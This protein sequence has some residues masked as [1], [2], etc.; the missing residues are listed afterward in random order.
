MSGALARIG[1]SDAQANADALRRPGP[2]S[3]EN[4]ATMARAFDWRAAEPRD[5][6]EAVRLARRAYA[7]EVPSALTEGSD[8]YYPDGS[9]R[10]SPPAE[11][12]IFGGAGPFRSLLAAWEHAAEPERRRAAIVRHVTIGARGPKESAIDEGVPSWCAALVAEDTLR[13][14]LRALMSWRL[15]AVA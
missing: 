6:R 9:P 4:R 8:T 10:M 1:R 15:G 5:L 11:A 14:F 12:Y 3:D 2:Y 13:A 7:E